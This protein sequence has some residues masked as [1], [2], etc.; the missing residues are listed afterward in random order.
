MTFVE[1][2]HAGIPF[3]VF[4]GCHPRSDKTRHGCR[5]VQSAVIIFYKTHSTTLYFFCIEGPT[6]KVIC[7]TSDLL[8]NLAMSS[9]KMVTII[10]VFDRAL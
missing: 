4:Q 6:L 5:S 8:Y 10:A 7:Q 3:A 9:C 2:K 1:K